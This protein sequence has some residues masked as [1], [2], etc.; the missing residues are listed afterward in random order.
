METLTLKTQIRNKNEKIKKLKEIK[1]IGWVI[2]GKKTEPISIKFN[3]SDFL[4]IFRKTWKSNILNL[5]IGKKSIEVIVYA[6]QKE[7]ISWDF[8]HIDFYA[9]TR[10]VKLQTNISLKFIW[11]SQA[12]KQWNILEEHMKNIEIKCLP[13]N[14][15]KE[16][17][18]DL[19]KLKEVW[20][21]IRVS[22]LE[23]DKDKYEILS[24]LDD[25]IVSVTK[26]AKVEEKDIE[27]TESDTTT[28]EEEET[29]K[30]EK[31]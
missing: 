11:E 13:M 19:S 4:K 24:N 20:D 18:I 10:W 15:V 14:L 1:Q 22:E 8:F 27:V 29:K 16:F 28:P 17:E 12:V 21:S 9:I 3:Y 7:A 26:P 25:M 30:E 6:I 23:I 31:K 2:Y 5:S